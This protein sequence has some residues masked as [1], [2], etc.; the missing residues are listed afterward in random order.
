MKKPL[1]LTIE[2]IVKMITET[3]KMGVAINMQFIP[4]KKDKENDRPTEKGGVTDNN[5]GSKTEKGDEGNENI[6]RE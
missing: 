4:I 3:E 5:V 2:D 6:F 1:K